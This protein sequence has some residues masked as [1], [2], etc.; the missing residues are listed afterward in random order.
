[1]DLGEARQILTS[2]ATAAMASAHAQDPQMVRVIVSY[3]PIA[4]KSSQ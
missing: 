2:S 3:P 4:G 1:M